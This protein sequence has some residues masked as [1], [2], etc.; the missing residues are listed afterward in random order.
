MLKIIY[1]LFFIVFI[2]SCAT[3]DSV[4][5]IKFG[6]SIFFV[7]SEED[8]SGIRLLKGKIKIGTQFFAHTIILPRNCAQDQFCS[9]L[10]NENVNLNLRELIEAVE[11][12]KE[13]NSKKCVDENHQIVFCASRAPLYEISFE[14]NKYKFWFGLLSGHPGDSGIP[15]VVK[16]IGDHFEIVK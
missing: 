14:N 6:D 11:L 7:Q 1:Y 16:R 13:H 15:T 3:A 5:K 8:L 4:K 9:V 10:V 12:V 2:T